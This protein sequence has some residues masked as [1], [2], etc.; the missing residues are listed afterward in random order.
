M[1]YVIK[2]HRLSEDAWKYLGEDGVIQGADIVV[3]LARWLNES[4]SLPTFQG[5]VGVELHTH[6][7]IQGLAPSLGKLDLVVINVPGIGDGRC[8]SLARLLRMRHGY[9]G[10]LRARGTFL[11][12]QL[13]YMQ[14]CGFNAY[15]LEAGADPGEALRSLDTF[16]VFYQSAADHAEP[17]IA[18][19][20][21]SQDPVPMRLRGADVAH[22]ANVA[23]PVGGDDRRIQSQ[24]FA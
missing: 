3:P 5:R 16:S 20:H 1:A 13:Q 15:E 19:R 8:F 2:D 21:R 14:R 6:D 23:S 9:R 12:D 22:R 4:E 24:P 10:E 18:L 11:I 17:A 7:D